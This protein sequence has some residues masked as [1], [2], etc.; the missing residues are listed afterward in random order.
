MTELSDRLIPLTAG[1][2][3]RFA[4]EITAASGDRGLSERDTDA[5]MDRLHEWHAIAEF[6]RL[7]REGHATM[8]Y[9]PG[10]AELVVRP[11]GGAP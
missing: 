11:I 1:E 5:A 8:A 7:W 3:R 6:M 2:Y 4:F 10:R 9:R